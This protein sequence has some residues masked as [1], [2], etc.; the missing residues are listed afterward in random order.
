RT[1]PISL[2]R[3]IDADNAAG[4]ETTTLDVPSQKAMP[5][6]DDSDPLAYYDADNPWGSVKVAGSGT[7]LRVVSQNKNGMMTLKVN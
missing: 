1:D 5:V 6:F 4:Y 3:E 2:H 7:T